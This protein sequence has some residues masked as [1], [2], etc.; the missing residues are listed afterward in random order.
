M[1]LNVCPFE[2]SEVQLVAQDN[3][4]DSFELP[5]AAKSTCRS[6]QL[7]KEDVD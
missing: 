5:V 2:V 7:D 1:T 6:S 4:K 3:R